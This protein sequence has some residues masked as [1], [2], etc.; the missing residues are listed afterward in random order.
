MASGKL[1]KAE[2]KML[3]KYA[4]ALPCVMETKIEVHLMKGSELLEIGY[5]EEEGKKID[6]KKTYPFNQPVKIAANHYRRL[7][8]AWMRNGEEGVQHYINNIAKLMKEENK[9]AA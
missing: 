3:R 9:N 4:D 2:E 8:N 7:K 5:V 1:T 6:P